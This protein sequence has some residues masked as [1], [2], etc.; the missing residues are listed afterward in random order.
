MD[1]NDNEDVEQLASHFCSLI[2]PVMVQLYILVQMNLQVLVSPTPLQT[3]I[4][5]SNYMTK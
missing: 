4:L 1:I 5:L 3:M 2:D